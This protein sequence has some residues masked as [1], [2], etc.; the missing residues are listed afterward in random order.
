MAS[1]SSAPHTTTTGKQSRLETPSI[2]KLT[3]WQIG[4]IYYRLNQAKSEAELFLSGY[5]KY[6]DDTYCTLTI[7]KL[8]YPTHST[9]ADSNFTGW[10]GS[11]QKAGRLVN[12]YTNS[13]AYYDPFKQAL[14]RAKPEPLQLDQLDLTKPE[15][16]FCEWKDGLPGG[17]TKLGYIFPELKSSVR[18]SLGRV[19]L[20]NE[21]MMTAHAHAVDYRQ[22][23]A[24]YVVKLHEVTAAFE[25]SL[26]Q[27]NDA[28]IQAIKA[29]I[30]GSGIPHE[31][32]R[33][34]EADQA[35][36]FFESAC[37]AMALRREIGDHVQAELA[38]L[39]RM[40]E[41]LP[42]DLPMAKTLT[43]LHE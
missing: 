3:D 43:A 38:T 26:R 35:T 37:E 24:Q 7:N 31:K 20:N 25:K 11:A 36:S 33:V 21:E 8:T 32:W 5:A 2:R 16:W 12:T 14:S 23:I 40:E 9:I 29:D 28:D 27:P 19:S 30:T 6:K 10:G 34:F 39:L 17:L 1:A 42:D 41:E 18:N 15:N 13:L 22:T 4:D